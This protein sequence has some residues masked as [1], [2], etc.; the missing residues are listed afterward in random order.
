MALTIVSMRMRS[1]TCIYFHNILIELRYS[2]FQNRVPSRRILLARR[3]DEE[4][5]D[6]GTRKREQLLADILR[7][8]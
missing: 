2:Y 5:L 4:R 8:V 7:N 6:V 3:S 1:Q